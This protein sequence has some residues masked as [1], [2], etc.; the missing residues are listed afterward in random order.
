MTEAHG[1]KLLLAVF[2]LISCGGSDGS[3]AVSET[4]HDTTTERDVD[5]PTT[6][7]GAPTICGWLTMP[8][9]R[10]DYVPCPSDEPRSPVSDPPLEDRHDVPLPG[11][12]DPRPAP[13]GD[14]P[15]F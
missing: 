4:D 6:D 13:P 9:G 10:L 2:L 11:A 8:N 1:P 14:P 15:P 12:P 3:P 7:P 5:Y